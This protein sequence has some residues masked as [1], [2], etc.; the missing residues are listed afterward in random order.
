MGIAQPGRAAADF[1]VSANTAE[2]S[3]QLHPSA[4]IVRRRKV[5]LIDLK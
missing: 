1:G 2:A 3:K 4:E 5:K